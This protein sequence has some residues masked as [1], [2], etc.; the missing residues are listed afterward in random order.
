MLLA[1]WIK[2]EEQEVW[3]STLEKWCSRHILFIEPKDH[4]EALL[5]EFWIQAMQE[6]LEQL[7]RNDVWELVKK[8]ADGNIVGKKWIFKKKIDENGFVVIN[9][10]R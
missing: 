6:E 1:R 8:P 3:R 7:I 4:T 2:E 5:D 9:K 10:A